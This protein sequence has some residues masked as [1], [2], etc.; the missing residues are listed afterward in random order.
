MVSV[1]PTCHLIR[2]P[3]AYPIYSHLSSRLPTFHHEP[4][5]FGRPRWEVEDVGDGSY[6]PAAPRSARLMIGWRSLSW[7]GYFDL[8]NA[9]GSFLAQMV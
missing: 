3:S 2:R 9:K 4:E 7:L 5:L 6:R 1:L 8:H